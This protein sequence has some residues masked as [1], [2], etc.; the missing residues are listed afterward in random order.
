M[1][2]LTISTE[3][4]TSLAEVIS[5]FRRASKMDMAGVLKVADDELVSSDYNGS[6]YSA[7]ID[8]P[9]CM[10]LNPQVNFR[11]CVLDMRS[12][13]TLLQ[14]FKIMAWY[15]NEWGYSNRLLDLTTHVHAQEA[16]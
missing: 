15:D 11:Q 5:A 4:P 10:E 14:F 16:V 3:K 12:L 1:I 9:S 7:I 2:D 6:P 8:A 13:L